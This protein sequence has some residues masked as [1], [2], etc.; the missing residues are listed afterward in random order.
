[1]KRSF[2]YLAVAVIQGGGALAGSLLAAGPLGPAKLG[3][4]SIGLLVAMMVRSLAA[5]GLYGPITIALHNEVDG[6]ERARSLLRSSGRLCIP[7][8]ILAIVMGATTAGHLSAFSFALASGFASAAGLSHQSFHRSTAD[9][10]AYATAMLVPSA[11][12]QAAGLIAIRVGTPEPETFFR[13][14][15]LCSLAGAVGQHLSHCRRG[16]APRRELRAA[17]RVGFPL[18]LTATA[19]GLLSLADRPLV[20][21]FR[22]SASVGRYH[23]IYVLAAAG[24]PLLGGLNNAWLPLVL[25]HTRADRPAVLS[26]TL[27]QVLAGMTVVGAGCAVAAPGLVQLVAGSGYDAEQL[28]SVALFAASVIVPYT[29][30]SG[31]TIGLLGEEH[32]SAIWRATFI[33]AAVNLIANSVM[34]PLLGLAG[35][36]LAATIGYAATA[37]VAV[38][39]CASLPAL[40]T[41][42]WRSRSVRASLV[43]FCGIGMVSCIVATTGPW[44][45]IRIGIGGLIAMAGLVYSARSVPAIGSVLVRNT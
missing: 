4:V 17:I 44:P 39:A 37:V 10:R 41:N 2:S 12:A 24:V 43:I 13:A 34:I 23:L 27:A 33:G 40:A 16:P 3:T 42:L 6:A 8:A 18:V 19:T 21:L 36:A 29:L 9:F 22:D 5:G 38:A 1:M 7:P 25:S 31:A 30:Y 45:T 14:V 20:E 15:A 32:T 35:A 11:L 28:R 26:Q